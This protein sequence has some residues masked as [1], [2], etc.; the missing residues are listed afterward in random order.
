MKLYKIK[1]HPESDGYGLMACDVKGFC[2]VF[3][4]NTGSWHRNKTRELD[5]AF[6][7]EAVYEH[8]DGAV[9]G[10]LIAGIKPADP[11]S[12]GR[13]IEELEQ[14]PAQWIKSSEDVGAVASEDDQ[15]LPGN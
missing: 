12:M 2:F 10:E 9:A 13:Y 6:G 7:P 1:S 14:Q 3:S 4:A 11:Q 8:I 5:L 15:P